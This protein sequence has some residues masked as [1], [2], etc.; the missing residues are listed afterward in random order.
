MVCIEGPVVPIEVELST[1]SA[2]R[3]AAICRGWARARHVNT[4]YYLAAPGPARAVER[5]VHSTNATDRIRVLGLDDIPLLAKELYAM[6]HQFPED[7]PA[8]DE[9][10]RDDYEDD[11]GYSDSYETDPS[12]REA[13]R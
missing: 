1:K 10:H 13:Y 12:P 4:V 6:E 2:S 5:A 9:S 8:E 11:P 7:D 3:L